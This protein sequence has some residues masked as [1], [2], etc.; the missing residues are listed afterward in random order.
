M[1][2]SLF[3]FVFVRFRVVFLFLY[4]LISPLEFWLVRRIFVSVGPFVG[5]FF[6]FCLV[7]GDILSVFCLFFW[8]LVDFRVFVWF[9]WFLFFFPISLNFAFHFLSLLFVLPGFP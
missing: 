4:P 8:F 5:W 1:I 6:A 3:R 7:F 9:V 2:F